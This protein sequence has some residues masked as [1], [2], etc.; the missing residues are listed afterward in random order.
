MSKDTSLRQFIRFHSDPMLVVDSEQKV[1]FINKAA[2]KRL[3]FSSA[4]Q[5]GQVFPYELKSGNVVPV[6]ADQLG[7]IFWMELSVAQALYEEKMLSIVTFRDVTKQYLQR[8][9]ILKLT[10]AVEQSP[11]TVVITDREGNIEYVNPR[12]TQI[13]GYTFAEVCGKNPRILKSG[14]QPADFYRE[15]WNT[16]L[17]EKEWRGEFQNKRKDG[18]F[19]WEYALIVPIRNSSGAVTH[20]LAVKEDVTTQKRQQ[21][22]LYLAHEELERIFNSAADAMCVVSSD[23][24]ILRINNAFMEYF[25]IAREE[26][27]GKKDYEVFNNAF[28]WMDSYRPL[29]MADGSY[30][31]ERDVDIQ[32]RDGQWR[33]FIVSTTPFF[34]ATGELAGTIKNFKDITER[35]RSEESLKKDFLLASRIQRESLPVPIQNHRVSMDMIYA[36]LNHVS[37]DFFGYSYDPIDDTL[38]G[39]VLDVMG[40]GLATALQTMAIRVLFEQTRERKGSLAS[41]MAWL[42]QAIIPYLAEDTF[43]AAIIFEF[44]FKAQK[45]TYVSCG[46]HYFLMKQPG[47][48][49]KMHR[50]SGAFLGLLED[51]VF[52][53]EQQKIQAGEQYYFFTDGIYDLWQDD[54]SQEA[55]F[56][57]V[58]ARL[59]NLAYSEERTDDATVVAIEVLSCDETSRSEN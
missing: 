42:N 29:P 7:K 31:S 20:Y 52:E 49:A 57:D 28:C 51:T 4:L 2:K 26:S 48:A 35:K 11:V 56:A 23:A 46:I 1:F 47:K 54:L 43:A 5:L 45:L 44:D 6:D 50:V 38:K 21:E 9:K 15:L 22:E 34:D 33:S 40:H 58:M 10:R 39:C 16:L 30:H 27:V 53:E 19:Y 3:N 12:F 36:P 18:S 24:T 55:T 14:E 8:E 32:R 41:K 25:Q 59:Q 13:T 37:G 17:A